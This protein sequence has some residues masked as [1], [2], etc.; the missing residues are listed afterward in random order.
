MQLMT[1]RAKK[2]KQQLMSGLLVMLILT[3]CGTTNT[4]LERQEQDDT[5]N[6]EASIREKKAVLQERENPNA[7]E[8]SITVQCEE[9]W[10]PLYNRVKADIESN[11]PGSEIRIISM[12]SMQFAEKT[13]KIDPNDIEAADIYS[14]P[15][16]LV[17]QLQSNDLL[18][19]VNVQ[20]IASNVGSTKN[21]GLRDSM[22]FEGAY[23]GYTMGIECQVAYMNPHNAEVNEIDVTSALDIKVYNKDIMPMAI[24]EYEMARYIMEDHSISLLS[25]EQDGTIGSDILQE[26]DYLSDSEQEFISALYDYWQRYSGSPLWNPSE[27]QTYLT[28]TFTSGTGIMHLDTSDLSKAEISLDENLVAVP[29]SNL[30]FAGVKLGNWQDGWAFVFNTRVEKN[31]EQ[32]LLAELFLSELLNPLR[33]AEFYLHTGKIIEHSII[34]DYETIDSFNQSIIS[35]VLNSFDDAKTFSN[36]DVDMLGYDLWREGLLSWEQESPKDAKAAYKLLQEPFEAALISED[37]E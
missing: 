14:V 23:Y 19:E 3:G 25:T 27:A 31:E 7:I 11:H 8:A 34:K 29:I 9:E 20:T 16:G 24:Y 17:E 10:L 32:M 36:E 6:V 13:M 30:S 33:A 5:S 12:D 37:E 35:A 18:S 2:M 21:Y 4:L 26:Y 28:E 1:N 22:K 15:V